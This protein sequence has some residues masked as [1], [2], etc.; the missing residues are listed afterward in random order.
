MSTKSKKTKDG[1]KNES[2]SGEK[3]RAV[4]ALTN[5]DLARGLEEQVVGLDV[6]MHLPRIGQVLQSLQHLIHHL[7]THADH[8]RDHD[9]PRQ[10]V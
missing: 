10:S 9:G 2:A 3:G 6:A 7:L 4:A 5:L 1:R 8:D